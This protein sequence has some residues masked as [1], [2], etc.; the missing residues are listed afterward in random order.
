MKSWTHL[1]AAAGM[2]L[3]E[4]WIFRPDAAP[5]CSLKRGSTPDFWRASL[6][7]LS[8]VSCVVL[9]T[10]GALE[11][12]QKNCE[13]ELRLMGHKWAARDGS[14]NSDESTTSA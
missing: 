2:G 13:K 12:A 8:G 11:Q 7:N 5:L 10:S 9:H 14:P 3:E 6:L 1:K 4:Q